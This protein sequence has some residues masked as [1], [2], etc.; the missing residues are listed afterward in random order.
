MDY[1]DGK[2]IVDPSTM[3]INGFK[4]PGMFFGILLGWFVE[5]RFVKF[6]TDTSTIKKVERCL[7]GAILVVLYWTVIV[8]PVGSFFKINLVYF[9]LRAS[10]PFIFMVIALRCTN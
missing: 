1:I 2:L 3:T 8:D 4:D 5:R 6:S 10:I 7:I 9:L